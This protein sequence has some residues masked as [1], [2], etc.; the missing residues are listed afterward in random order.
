MGAEPEP[1]PGQEDGDGEGEG[2]K[3]QPGLRDP[4]VVHSLVEIV[5][6]LG[7]RARAKLQRRREPLYLHPDPRVVRGCVHGWWL[8]VI[9]L[10]H[11][12]RCGEWRGV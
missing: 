9:A 3:Q 4:E 5:M 6:D 2:P 12:V 8:G 11:S 7:Q 1:E 10:A